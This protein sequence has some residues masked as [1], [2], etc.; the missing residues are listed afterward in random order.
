MSPVLLRGV[1]LCRKYPMAT[2]LDGVSL[3]LAPGRLVALVGASGSGK[4]TLARCLAGLEPPDSGMVQWQGNPLASLSRDGR[5]QFRRQVQLVMQ[6]ASAAL[7]PR[8]NGLNLVREPLELLRKDLPRAQR[9]RCARQWLERVGLPADT[10][11]RMPGELSGGQRQRLLL[12][13]AMTLSPRI[14]LLDEPLTGLDTPVQ[15]AFL[16]LL[17]SLRKE[18]ELGCLLVTHSIAVALSIADEVAVMHQGQ[19]EERCPAHSFAALARHPHARSLLDAARERSD[20]IS[21]IPYINPPAG[22][23]L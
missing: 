8:W 2:A 4:S 5:R 1:A 22:A 18:Q 21:Q 13:R 16:E 20:A 17:L 15:A 3:D 11:A 9:E 7:N 14:L 10:V 6:D 19:M 23:P 12:A